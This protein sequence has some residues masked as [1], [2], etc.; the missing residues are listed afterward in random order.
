MSTADLELSNTATSKALGII[1]TWKALVQ[2]RAEVPNPFTSINARAAAQ[3]AEDDRL[4]R[5]GVKVFASA[6]S[7]R[8]IGILVDAYHAMEAQSERDT[9]YAA[10]LVGMVNELL[11]MVTEMAGALAAPERAAAAREVAQAT[12]E[13]A[14]KPPLSQLDSILSKMKAEGR[15]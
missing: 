14:S 2:A 8:Q 7:A 12:A 13:Q 11:G 9:A 5:S 15:I 1:T 3:A 6:S 4:A 10:D